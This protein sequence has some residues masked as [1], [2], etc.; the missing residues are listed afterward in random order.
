MSRL[1]RLYRFEW[2]KL[3]ARRLPL[4]AF[5]LVV[6]VALIAPQVGQV[7]DTAASLMRSGK[8]GNADPFA[9]GW[10]ALAGAVGSTRMFLVI[11]VL[12][13]AGSSV[14]E[15]SSYRTLQAMLV[16]PVRRVEILAAKALAIWSYASLLLVCA[17]AMAALGAELDQGLY[18][19]VDPD[20]PDRLTH[21]FGDM[22]GYVYLAVGLTLLP[23]LALTC[24]GLLA[25]TLFDHPGYA[26]G[27]AIGGLFVAS[28]AAGLS[29]AGES[30]LFVSYLRVPFEVVGDLAAQY[31]N[32]RQRLSGEALVEALVVPGVWAAGLFGAGALALV[33][34]DI[35]R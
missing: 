32:V 3:L 15:E 1:W 8:A 7:V 14:A 22:W 34:R 20:Y 11:V 28:A 5:A 31:T 35:D 26:T 13:L 17:V 10:T 19:V 29:D 16:R 6:L 4:V 2:E 25:S 30:L 23:L 21:A 27:V 33:R 12:I 18:D 24:M 9:N